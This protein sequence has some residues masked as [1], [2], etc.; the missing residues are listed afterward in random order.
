MVCIIEIIFIA[1]NYASIGELT[2]VHVSDTLPES[3]FEYFRFV[4]YYSWLR[5]TQLSLAILAAGVGVS[6]Y[7]F[8]R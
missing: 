3:Y 4:Q 7:G 5:V 8:V 2:L 6:V 1:K